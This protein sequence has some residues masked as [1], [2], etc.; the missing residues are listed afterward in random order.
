MFLNAVF[1]ILSLLTVLA[2]L[3]PTAM[4]M[5]RAISAYKTSD[6]AWPWVCMSG[7]SLLLFALTA[8]VSLAG[9]LM[10]VF[11]SFV[12]S[13]NGDNL[14]PAVLASLLTLASP[15]MVWLLGKYWIEK[16]VSP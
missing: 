2:G 12:F 9:L 14:L 15:W 7:L 11:P 4:A 6:P 5:D 10:G 1:A 3:A 8:F 13:I 16:K